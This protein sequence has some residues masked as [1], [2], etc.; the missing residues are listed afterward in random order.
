MPGMVGSMDGLGFA[1]RFA[2]DG[3]RPWRWLRARGHDL[4]FGFRRGRH[5]RLGGCFGVGR[6]NGFG[7]SRR[8]R[9]AGGREHQDARKDKS[10]GHQPRSGQASLQ[11]GPGSFSPRPR[12]FYR[13]P[14]GQG[15][16]VRKVGKSGKEAVRS[17]AD[18]HARPTPRHIR[19]RALPARRMLSQD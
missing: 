12:G 2:G 5:C 18:R 10:S 14:A 19:G 9:V 13:I 6:G 3:L 16:P 11:S 7:D 4:R 15:S 1:W 17:C 8:G